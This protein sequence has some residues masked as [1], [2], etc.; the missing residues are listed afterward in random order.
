MSNVFKSKKK[1]LFDFEIFQFQQEN[2]QLLN[3]MNSL[4][5]EVKAIEGKVVEIARLQE[6]FSEQVLIFVSVQK[7][8]LKYNQT[9]SCSVNEWL[10]NYHKRFIFRILAF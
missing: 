1:N 4:V 2:L 7:I 8:L 3:D 5:D 9:F 6:M 10:Y